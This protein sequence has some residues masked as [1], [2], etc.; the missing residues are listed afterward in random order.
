MNINIYGIRIPYRSQDSNIDK[1]YTHKMFDVLSQ[2]YQSVCGKPIGITDLG[3]STKSF[4]FYIACTV[5]A[6]IHQSV[7]GTQVT[8]FKRALQMLKD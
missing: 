5:S 7:M 8:I 4:G 1:Y 3:N 6:T 2:A